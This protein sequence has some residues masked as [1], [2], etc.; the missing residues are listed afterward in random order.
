M[1]RFVKI[2]LF[3]FVIFSLLLSSCGEFTQDKKADEGMLYINLLWH[4]HQPLYYKNADGVYTRPWVRVHAT[5]DYYDMAS[6]IK[7][8]PEIHM[9]VNL[10][11]VLLRQL[12]DFVDNGAKDLYWELAEKDAGQ[13]TEEEKR[14][15]LTRFFD[16]NYDNM[17]GRFPRYEELL[18]KRGGI[19]EAAIEAA[20]LSFSE[21][22]IRD[23]QIWFNLAWFD[24][25]FLAE[26]PLASLVQ[27]GKNFSESDKEI[28]FGQVRGVMAAIVPLHKELQDAGQLEVITTPYAHPILPLIYN[29]DVALVGNPSSVLEE[30]FSWPN[31]AITHLQ[32]SV[33]IYQSLFGRS[34]R[35]LWPGEGSVSEDVV[36]L[37]AE[38]GYSWMATGEPV[39]AMSLGIDSFTRD[40]QET[41]Q[42][43][44]Q[45][46]RPYYVQ[47]REDEQVAVF[48]RDWELSDKVGFEYSQTPGKEAAE[49]LIQRLEN[50][51]ARL[52]EEEA[53]GPHIVSIILDGENAWEYYPNDGKEFLNSIYTLLSESETLKTV[54]PS[55]YL[56]M[57][58]EQQILEY[59]FPGAWF[60]ANYD[61]WIGETEENT[62]WGYLAEVRDHLAKYDVT[63]RR[64]ASPEAIEAAEDFMY[65]AEGSDWFWWYG[66]DQDSGQDEYFDEGFREL[67]KGVYLSLGDEV[68]EF[69]NVPI[70]PAR[71]AEAARY[72]QGTFTPVV[73]G[74]AAEYEW[75]KSAL[76]SEVLTKPF[77]DVYLG[78]DDKNLYI[79][80]DGEAFSSQSAAGLYLSLPGEHQTTAFA[81]SA[82]GEESLLLGVSAALFFDWDEGTLTSYQVEGSDWLPYESSAQAAAGSMLE[83]QIPLQELG[84]LAG[85]DEIRLVVVEP[86]EKE[87][88]PSAGPA[89][90]VLPDLGAG[91]IV[92]SIND[93]EGDDH[94]PGT[95]TYAEDGVFT[96]QVFDL[97]QFTVSYDEN[98]LVFKFMMFGEVPNP[99][100]SGNNL[101]LQTL[102]VY[103]DTNPG[104]SNGSR[105]LLPGR[106]AALAEGGWDVAI[107]AEGWESAILKPDPDTLE[108]KPVN[109][110]FK[111]LVNQADNSVT[112]RVPR[113]VFGEGSPEDW[114]YAAAVLSQDGYPSLGVW[115]VRDIHEQ[116]EQWYFGGAPLDN[117]HTR[118]I[119]LAWPEGE[120]GGQE[121]QLSDYS[122]SSAA[123][124]EL[125]A[126]D[127]PQIKWLFP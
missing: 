67:L 19:D 86:S 113:E 109:Q 69:L 95:Y 56:E 31:D 125:S 96:E 76:Y 122:S 22:D 127:F 43:A 18:N 91:T 32:K 38:A 107:W 59:L 36:P 58:P 74:M 48:F 27:K 83:V 100:G 106:N 97:K 16:A 126:D 90:L 29:T 115:R 77:S 53:E 21:Q 14:F 30:R 103:V 114:A 15:I 61:T 87:T 62:A 45:L 20:M 55:E 68:P 52:I 79:R 81:R 40:S 102:D 54:T 99:W 111:I 41:V 26:E 65:L 85:G 72:L 108:P 94:G 8:Y 75:D 9:T 112:L 49:D 12:Q 104:T 116:S 73:D 105:L 93:P 6:I 44:D 70:I 46:Y 60:S 101:S 63:G 11:P 89:Q 24:P 33:E 5:K 13:L 23:L 39:L 51:R 66:A 34:P 80:V 42:Q 17:I 110:S 84:D 92:L 57:F 37:I 88:F 35:G 50:I 4:Q 2:L 124:S 1:S 25:Q 7:D 98:S 120:T 121:E 47:G 28:V 82:E 71:P 119:D 64:E 117:N 123:V 78:L 118:I 3:I 10:T